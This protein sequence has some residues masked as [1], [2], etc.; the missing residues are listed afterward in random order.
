MAHC[1]FRSAGRSAG[2]SPGRSSGRWGDGRDQ[3][4]SRGR[5]ARQGAGLLGLL[6]LGWALGGGIGPS[7]VV[8]DPDYCATSAQCPYVDTPAGKVQQVC[9]TGRHVCVSGSCFSDDDCHDFRSPRCDPATLTCTSCNLGDNSCVRFPDRRL[10]I[11]AAEGSAATLCGACETHLDCPHTAPVCDGQ[12]CRP[13]AT[14]GDCEG[15]HRC[16]NDVMCTDSLVCI[17]EGDLGAELVGRCAQNGQAASG[18]VIYVADPGLCDDANPGNELIKPVCSLDAAVKKAT[19]DNRRFIRLVGATFSGLNDTVSSGTFSFIGAPAKSYKNLATIVGNGQFF[20]VTGTAAVTLDSLHLLAQ[21]ANTVLVQCSGFGNILPSLTLRNNI[22]S[23]STPPDLG[24]AKVGAV[25]LNNCNTVLDG[26]I[27]GVQTDSELKNPAVT[28]HGAALLI[29]DTSTGRG[30]SYLVQNNL[31]AGNAGYAV[32]LVGVSSDAARFVF[33]FNTIL[34][35]ARA[36]PGTSGAIVCPIASSMIE[37][38]HSIVLNNSTFSDG[39]Q[40]LFPGNCGLK[41]LVVGSKETGTDPKF[42]L[43]PELDDQFQ[44]LR[45]AIDLACCIDKVVPAGAETLPRLDLNLRP[46]PQGASWDIGATELLP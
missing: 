29:N 6:V 14:H 13:C 17:K 26:N 9:N 19:T 16:D 34:G 21:R 43:T 4:G 31:V 2:R 40:F 1:S 7:C 22:L 37:F 11:H 27:I 42:N 45:G 24:T 30:A 12:K 20:A 44:L 25:T 10:C 28:V 41:N 46:R 3:E 23:G 15:E 32:N 39:S 38:S 36:T 8:A 18:K 33:R 35:N 5:P